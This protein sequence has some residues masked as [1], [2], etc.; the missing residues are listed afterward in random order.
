MENGLTSKEVIDRIKEGKQ[1]KVSKKYS[2][3]IIRIIKNNIFTIFNGINLFLAILVFLTGSYKNLLFVFVIIINTAI[4]IH[5]E[6]RAKILIDKLKISIQDKVEVIRD[7]K[8]QKIDSK[9]L[10]L[11]DIILLKQGEQAVV[12]VEVLNSNLCEVDESIIT[13]ES[14]NIIKKKSDII[15]SGSIIVS[16]NCKAKVISVGENNYSSLLV[17]NANKITSRDSYLQESL[18]KILK[19]ITIIIIPLMIIM[20]VIKYFFTNII[21]QEAILS[22]VAGVIGMIP[23]GLMLLTSITSSVGIIKLAHKKTIV[24]KINGIET[25]ASVDVLCLDKTGT[26]TDGTFDVIDVIKLQKNL[27]IDNIIDNMIEDDV[28]NQTDKA[29]SK[30]FKKNTSYEILKKVPFSS[31]RKY[32]LVTFKNDNTYALGALEYMVSNYQKYN[33]YIKKYQELGYRIITLI[34]SKETPQNQEIPK[35]NKVVAFIILKDNIRKNVKETLTYLKNENVELKIISGDNPITISNTLKQIGYE[36]Y[37]SYIDCSKLSDDF[38]ELKEIANNYSIFGRVTPYQKRAIIK[39][40]KINKKVGMIG[41]GVNDILALKE[42][43]SSIALAS[44]INAA[45]SVSQIVLMKSDFTIIPSIMNEGRRVVNNIEKVASLY[46]IKTIYSIILSTLSIIF[47]F[48]YPF[49]P[50]QLTAISSLCVGLPSFIVALE[51][52]IK[53]VDNNIVKNILVNSIPYGI[54]V[55]INILMLL[56]LTKLL[57]LDIFNYSAVIVVT[58]GLVNL[59]LLSKIA[60]K[61]NKIIKL[62]L[63]ICGVAF[64]G[65]V[66]I[67]NELFVVKKINIYIILMILIYLIMDIYLIKYLKLIIKDIFR[68]IKI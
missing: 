38:Y 62:L 61:S 16:G 68:K 41:D 14:K 27:D 18:N 46:L 29:L 64:I 3:S 63:L 37:D 48:T 13:G 32:S 35:N 28:V 44:G 15:Y 40:L 33:K 51:K 31:E 56:L 9:N 59:L 45:R 42:A 17:K 55:S 5:Q 4:A 2:K 49:Y 10:V 34:S 58:T 11:D 67:F 47:N 23:S 12:D 1:N 36:N 43:D 30:Y 22:T 53:R 8:K 57:N 20:F 66:T 6:I 52:N 21:W 39:I 25:L 65:I 50:I 60:K 54:A 24:Q 7:F 26:I 19:L